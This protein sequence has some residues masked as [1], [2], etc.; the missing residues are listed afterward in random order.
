MRCGAAHRLKCLEPSGGIVLE[1]RIR[2]AEDFFFANFNLLKMLK[3][4]G[5]VLKLSKLMGALILAGLVQ[6]ALD[7][8]V[9]KKRGGVASP[10]NREK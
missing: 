2:K 4:G 7:A 8:Q 6:G 10:Q 3:F 5:K 1:S 9:V